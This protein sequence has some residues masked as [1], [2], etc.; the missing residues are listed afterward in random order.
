MSNAVKQED[1]SRRSFLL[2]LGGGVIGAGLLSSIWIS[3]RSL[4]PNVLYEPPRKF[5][6][7]KVDSFPQGMTFIEDRRVYL[8]RDGNSFY[9]I[10]GVCSHLGCTVKYSPFSNEKEMTVRK[11][12]YKSKGEFHCPCHGSKFRDEGTNYAGPAPKALEWFELA[13]APDDGQ[14]IINMAHEV[15]REFRLVV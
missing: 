2:K 9:A 15:G 10:S 4:L 14:L 6:V 5:K 11:K 8:F 7:G 12:T 13:L 1:N 3:V